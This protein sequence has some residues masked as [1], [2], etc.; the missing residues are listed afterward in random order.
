MLRWWW[1]RVNCRY[2]FFFFF[3]AHRGL[4]FYYIMQCDLPPLR[5]HCGEALGRD[6][7]PEWFRGRDTD[8][9]TTTPPYCR[10]GGG[11]WPEPCWPGLASGGSGV[12]TGIPMREQPGKDPLQSKLTKEYYSTKS[13]LWLA[14][15]GIGYY[16][17]K[18]ILWLAHKG[19]LFYKEYPLVSSQSLSAQI[20]Q[21]KNAA[22][23]PRIIS[24]SGTTCT[25]NYGSLVDAMGPDGLNSLAHLRELYNHKINVATS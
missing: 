3:T 10:C 13:I 15:K 24:S 16:S 19:I 6:L 8:H 11:A 17:T 1:Y 2:F 14:H 9:S 21:L 7:N 4:G 25:S 18:S 23:A 12:S 5:P 22:T 20:R